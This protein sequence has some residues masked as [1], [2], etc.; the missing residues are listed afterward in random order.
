MLTGINRFQKLNILHLGSSENSISQNQ[1]IFGRS[2]ARGLPA[3]LFLYWIPINTHS[4]NK[5]L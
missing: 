5:F 4:Q 3:F 1:P 2:M